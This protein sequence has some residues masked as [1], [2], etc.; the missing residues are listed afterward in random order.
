MKKVLNGIHSFH[1]LGLKKQLIAVAICAGLG[2]SVNIAH[3]ASP[4]V[5][6]PAVKAGA[7][8]VYVVKKGDTLWD[9]SG[10]FLSKPWRWPEIWAS[11]KHVKN[12]HWIYPGD[13]LLLCTLNGK[14]L[15]GK[16]EGDGCAG[17]IRRHSGNTSTLRPQVRVEALNNSVPVIPLAHIQQWLERTS[18]LPVDTIAHTPYILGT[19]DK[20]VLAGKGQSVYVRGKGLE[21]GQRYGVFREGEPYII[22]DEHGKKQNLGI[23]LT[24]VASGVA[25]RNENDITTVELTDS[26]N[27]E[28]RRGDRVMAEQD[29]MLPTLFYPTDANQVKD[30]GKIIRV[31]GSIGTAAKNGV[32]TVDRGTNDGIEIGQVFHAYQD[33]ETVK[34]PKTKETVKLPGQ[35]VGNVMIFK[36]FDRLSYAYVL[37]SDL[38]I[39]V[40]SNIKPP[41]LED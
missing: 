24:Q 31:M 33:G 7:P 15:I 6:P 5:S 39:K 41:R 9:I 18:I 13:R 19:A 38:P 40:G 37:E 34:D 23:E 36:S 32:V 22:V 35:Y 10:K 17:I 21:N 29:A 4:N 20:R 2:M 25:I 12:P 11:N 26:Y 1:A 27:G 30:G 8:H 3:A 16:D 28:V 14:P